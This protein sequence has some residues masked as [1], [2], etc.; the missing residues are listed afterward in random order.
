MPTLLT[1]VAACPV[2][3]NA[4]LSKMEKKLLE[5]YDADIV[6]LR[7]SLAGTE[8]LKG[9]EYDEHG[10]PLG[11]TV[12]EWFDA[13]D[14]KLIANGGEEYREQANQRRSEWN[15]EGQWKFDML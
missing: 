6:R 4:S 5:Q 14:Q 1:P 3:S 7:E 10:I 12:M 15:K 11:Y 2:H 9:V 13:L 8:P